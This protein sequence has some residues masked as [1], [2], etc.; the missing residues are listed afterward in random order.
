MG[1][2]ELCPMRNKIS[3]ISIGLIR[4]GEPRTCWSLISDI[5]GNTPPKACVEEQILQLCALI[6][7]DYICWNMTRDII[8]S[9]LNYHRK[10]QFEVPNWQNIN[11]TLKAPLYTCNITCVCL[12]VSVCVWVCRPIYKERDL[13]AR[14]PDCT[15]TY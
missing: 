10:E 9:I 1:L 3:Q 14:L 7:I 12:C 15:F 11:Q 4:Q 5:F 6:S 8:L 2:L 13:I